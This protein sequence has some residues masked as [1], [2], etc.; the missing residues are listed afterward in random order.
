M[1]ALP[2]KIEATLKKLRQTHSQVSGVLAMTQVGS[3]LLSTFPTSDIRDSYAAMAR[4]I[5]NPAQVS[6]EE[7]LGEDLEFLRFSTSKR[8]FLL[9]SKVRWRRLVDSVRL[10]HPCRLP[11]FKCMTYCRCDV[12]V[13]CFN[14]NAGSDHP[15]PSASSG[16]TFAG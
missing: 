9:I 3:V 8:K 10:R 14:K 7:N 4:A 5:L 13:V 15:F 11:R 1:T 16:D 6:V 12:S 2:P